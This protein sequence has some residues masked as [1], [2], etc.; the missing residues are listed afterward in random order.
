MPPLPST[1][2]TRILPI[3]LPGTAT[4]LLSK[5]TDYH[6]LEHWQP[7]LRS[8]G[9]PRLD[10]PLRSIA[11]PRHPTRR[12]VPP[13]TVVCC[14]RTSEGDEVIRGRIFNVQRFSVHDGPGIR[15]TV[16]LKGCPLRCVW[17]LKPDGPSEHRFRQ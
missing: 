5:K 3:L 2:S 7:P 16:F 9:Q 10:G 1:D 8:R 6:G 17:C 14:E 11:V 12:G 13:A 15:T 4:D